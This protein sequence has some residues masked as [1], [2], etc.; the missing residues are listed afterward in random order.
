MGWLDEFLV[1]KVK[2]KQVVTDASDVVFNNILYNNILAEL[3]DRYD[4]DEMVY[5]I[6]SLLLDIL[7]EKGLDDRLDDFINFMPQHFHDELKSMYN[8][9][10]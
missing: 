6:E 3:I 1:R 8:D 7:R 4:F 10:N 5:S 9:N 2:K